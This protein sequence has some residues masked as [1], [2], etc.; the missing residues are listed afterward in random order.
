MA[1]RKASLASTKDGRWL[2][3]IHQIPPT[4][5]Y[6]RVKIGR[7]LAKL[8]AVAIKNS[9]YALPSSDSAREDFQWV[10][11][12]IVKVGGDASVI[13][14][15]FVE[16]LNDAQVQALF[17]AARDADYAQIAAD[18]KKTL[19]SLPRR[20]AVADERR[21]A[22]ESD[23]A[24]LR[25]RV[26]EVAVI[27][28][29]GTSGRVA[30][31]GLLATIEERLAE[32]AKGEPDEHHRPRPEVMRGRTWVTRTGIHVDRIACAWLIRRFI[33]QGAVIRFVNAK[34]YRHEAGNLRF[35]MYDGEYTHEGDACSFE[36][37]TQRF[38]L[39]EPAI[40]AIG[41]V[42]HDLDLKDDKFG[43]P[44]VAGV[45]AAITGICWANAGD[46]QRL[47]VG[48]ALFDA[49]LEFYRRKAG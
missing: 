10:V 36:V 1:K 44:E 37:L 3:L 14:A 18:A 17:N 6:L 12:E 46:D 29:F 41:E 2:L 13:A 38:A 45:G 30:V 5:A 39:E 20:R 34:T 26:A 32:K 16:G 15:Q 47:A 7:R 43:R 24:R 8:G 28:F 48:A 49:L 25:Q 4:P 22:V 27:D 33:D 31:E 23:L 19:A 11:R 9:V 42:I 40:H 21:G 35:D